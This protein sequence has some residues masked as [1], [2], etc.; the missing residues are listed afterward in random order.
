MTVKNVIIVCDYGYIEGGAAKIAHET[1]IEL[2]KKGL[3][4]VFFCAVGPIAATF[5][6][7]DVEV[8]CL[9]QQDILH[10]KN[11]LKGILQGIGNKTAK[12]KFSELLDRFDVN[13]TVIHVHTWTKAVSSCI[14]RVARKKKFKVLITVHDYFLICPNGGL[15]N[16]PKR[17]IC[18]LRPM[19]AKCIFCNCDARSYAQKCFR[20]MRQWVQDRNIRR[21]KNISYI[22]ISEFSKREFLKRYKKIPA[23][24]QYFL[25]NMID[26]PENR[27][28]VRCEEN[29]V[30]L[31]IGGITEVKGIRIFCEAVTQ[32]NV[33]AVAIGQGILKEELEKS[34]PNIEFVGWKS[35]DEMIPYLQKAR[36]LIFP[37]IWYEVSPLTPLEV[38]AYGIPVICSN[39]NAA[40]EYIHDGKS[41]LKYDGA[42]NNLSD[43]ITVTSNVSE[44]IEHMSKHIYEEF[45]IG[46]Y[47][48]E[49]YSDKLNKIYAEALGIHLQTENLLY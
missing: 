16:Y 4:V 10:E 12:K 23:D 44:L 14:F 46:Q 35:R 26:I 1:A 47:S 31:F 37:S 33:K 6:K 28:R 27:E 7:S 18:E 32:A 41:G 43:V 48:G 3:H 11:R 22:F 8:V 39:L 17:R 45:N 9:N 40:S 20:V 2:Q 49:R 5:A 19:S 34:Y 24:R 25:P 30:Y 38:M 13:E 36:C 21:S 15:F 29:D 42:S